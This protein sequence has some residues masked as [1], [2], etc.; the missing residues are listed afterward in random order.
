[1][2]YPLKFIPVYKKTLWGGDKIRTHFNRKIRDQKIGESWEICCRE[3]GM[4][5][6]KNGKFQG[7]TLLELINKF[8]EK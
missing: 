5:I 6:V 7:K 2:L 4:S 8:T 1:M 3:D